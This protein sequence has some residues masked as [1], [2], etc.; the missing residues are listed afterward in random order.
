MSAAVDIWISLFTLCSIFFNRS[1]TIYWLVWELLSCRYCWLQRF[2]ADVV[3]VL[4]MTMSEGREC[5]KYRLL[6]SHEH[7]GSWG[8]EYVRLV[9]TSVSVIDF[10]VFNICIYRWKARPRSLQKNIVCTRL[11]IAFKRWKFAQ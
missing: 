6:G 5:L 9:D 8:H 7:I 2:C 10:N 4:G 1:I 11:G 3:S